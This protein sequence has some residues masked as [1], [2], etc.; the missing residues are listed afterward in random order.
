MGTKKSDFEK[1]SDEQGMAWFHQTDDELPFD[2]FGDSDE[3]NRIRSEIFKKVSQ[4]ISPHK[5]I[6]LGL[7]RIAAAI[8]LIASLSISLYKLLPR[9]IAPDK[10]QIWTVYRAPAGTVRSLTLADH[11]VVIL[12]SGTKLYVPAT[13]TTSAKRIVKLDGGEAYFSIAPDSKRPFLVQSGKIST[14]VVGTAF[15]IRNKVSSGEVEVAVSHGKVQ[16]KDNTRHLAD[17]TKGR[18]IRYYTQSQAFKLD[19]INTSYVAA[20]SSSA[21]ELNDVSF[22][23]L[24]YVVN[25]YYGTE[26]V[27][28]GADIARLRFTLTINKAVG[29]QSILKII[30]KIHGLFIKTQN[31]KIILHK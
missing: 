5:S 22:N 12:R 16:V 21:I 2:A 30:T 26:L 9:K 14:Q 1:D 25:S 10:K 24:A 20:W 8:L 13:F 6:R 18:L 23:E 29:A 28:A 31:G 15:N 27:A 19:S 11:S 17:L 7:L 4:K 3:E